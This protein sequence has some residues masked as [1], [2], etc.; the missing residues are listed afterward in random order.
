MADKRSLQ[1]LMKEI[2]KSYGEQ[3]ISLGAELPE[4]RRI[5]FSSPRAN[6]MTYGGIPRGRIIEFAGEEGSGKTTTALDIC[7]NAMQVFQKEWQEE[8]DSLKQI[9]KPTKQQ[10]IR[11]DEL[12]TMGPKKILYA[13]LENT[14]DADWCDKLGLDITEI[15]FYKAQGQN[16]E[17]IFEDIIRAIETE[18][19]GLVVID[20]LGVMISAQAYEK[21]IEQKT[22]GGISMPLTL[23]SKKANASCKKTGC[24]LI[25]INQV[26]DNL[27]SPYGGISTPGGKAWK[28][29]A[30]LRII[31]QKGDFV[32]SDGDKIARGSESPAGNKVCM[33][34]KKTKA[35]K[36]D[37]RLGY[38][39]LMYDYGI[40]ALS[41]LVD[42]CVVDGV[43][44]KGGAWFTFIN[45]VTGEVIVD[46]NG[47]TLKVQGRSNVLKLLHEHEELR[48]IYKQFVD[49]MIYN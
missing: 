43:I 10:V 31:F 6:Y 49:N 36:P 22:Y 1:D 35:F 41:D 14:L 33:D 32:D 42:M 19:L 39:T 47:S 17:E 23:F 9:E 12:D 4:V 5:P 37:R 7:V 8:V 34:I 45:P 13:D 48:D 15:Y 46:D 25:G 24:T 26:R 16:A 11:L 2:N 27:N 30:S 28:H 38:Y 21:S 3:I 40:D 18:E 20:S 29:N 44:Q